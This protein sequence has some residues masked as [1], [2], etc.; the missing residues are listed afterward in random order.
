MGHW[1]LHPLRPLATYTAVHKT[2]MGI[3][4]ADPR[5]VKLPEVSEALTHEDQAS[6]LATKHAELRGF[7]NTTGQSNMVTQCINT[8]DARFIKCRP[9]R[10]SAAREEVIERTERESGLLML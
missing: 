9:A 10:H 6:G 7:D 4:A 1:C 3:K 8:A 2:Y 5:Q